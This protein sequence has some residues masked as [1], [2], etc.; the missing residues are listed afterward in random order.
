[1]HLLCYLLLIGSYGAPGEIRTPDKRLK[2]ALLYLL[3][4][5]RVMM[6]DSYPFGYTTQGAHRAPTTFHVQRMVAQESDSLVSSSTPSFSATRYWEYT[7]GGEGGIRTHAG[8]YTPRSFQDYSLKPL[9][10]PSVYSPVYIY[11]KR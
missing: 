9:E 8:C 1:M 7:F 3:S 6:L 2:R 4:Y 10:Y 5:R 11:E